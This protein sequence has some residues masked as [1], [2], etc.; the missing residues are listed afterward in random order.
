MSYLEVAKEI[1]EQDDIEGFFK[2]MGPAMIAFVPYLI[3]WCL[4]PDNLQE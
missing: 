2:G 1:Y 4:D 3:K